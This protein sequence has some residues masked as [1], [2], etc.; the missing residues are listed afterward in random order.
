MKEPLHRDPVP[1]SAR[2]EERL[3][4]FIVMCLH[5]TIAKPVTDVTGCGNPGPP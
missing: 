5:M 3:F 4:S 1:I 2:G